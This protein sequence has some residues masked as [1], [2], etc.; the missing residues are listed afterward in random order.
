MTKRPHGSFVVPMTMQSACFECMEVA[1][2]WTLQLQKAVG[3]MMHQHC[4]MHMII[5][6]GLLGL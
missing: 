5:I 3:T 6:K 2:G 1:G 4:F